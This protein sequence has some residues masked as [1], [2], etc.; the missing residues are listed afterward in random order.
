[1]LAHALYIVCVCVYTHVRM[2]V[3]VHNVWVCI[4]CLLSTC[5]QQKKGDASH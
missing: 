3:G 1:M 4:M 2:C 5:T